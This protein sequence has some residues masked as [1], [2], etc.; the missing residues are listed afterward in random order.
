MGEMMCLATVYVEKEGQREEVMHDVAWVRCD[1]GH[2]Q[3]VSLMRESQQLDAR[4]KMIDLM[5]SSII[6][7]RAPSNAPQDNV[8]LKGQSN[9]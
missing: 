9:G 4:I 1:D 2:L 5:T 7:E 6:L 8:Q 3:L